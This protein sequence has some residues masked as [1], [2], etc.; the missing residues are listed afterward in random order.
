MC[1][2]IRILKK[3]WASLSSAQQ[4]IIL[5]LLPIV[6][7]PLI[8]I[9]CIPYVALAALYITGLVSLTAIG[10]GAAYAFESSTHTKKREKSSDQDES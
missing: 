10:V 6:L 9:L 5:F 3:Y 1:A 8:T 7:I 4:K 2:T